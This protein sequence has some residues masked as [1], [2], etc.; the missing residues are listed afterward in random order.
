M[1]INDIFKSHKHGGNNYILKAD[2]K[3]RWCGF[4]KNTIDKLKTIYGNE[5]NLVIWGN[6]SDSDYYCIPFSHVSHL[7]VEER[8]TKGT[9]AEQGNKR[10]TAT[11]VGHIFKMHANSRYSINIEIFY[12]LKKPIEILTLKQKEIIYDIDY[13]IEDYKAEVNV[14]YGQSEFRRKVLENFD[15][16][17]CLTGISES[18]FLIASHIIPWSIDKNYRGDPSNG[19]CLFLEYD[20]YFDKGYI[21][22]DD[23]L[24]VIVSDEV[25]SFTTELK[26]RI[27]RVKGKSICKP[28]KWDINIEHIKIHRSEVF[29]R[30]K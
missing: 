25:E 14:R 6:K 4:N 24:K 29:K 11:I 7:F 10:W 1:N 9:L 8:M 27:Y 28:V 3:N 2:S 17:C 26:E 22:L 12:G 13:C 19:L 18:N 16:K 20:A 21:T 23:D 30:N 5:F 15:N